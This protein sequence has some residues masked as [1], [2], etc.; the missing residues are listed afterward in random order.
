MGVTPGTRRGVYEITAQIGEGGM[1]KVFRARDTRL[2]REVAIKVIAAPLVTP[3]R[4]ARFER[5]A[6]ALA[7]LNHPH[8]AQVYG[9]NRPATGGARDI[10]R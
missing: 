9:S 7:S 8:I 4:V 6:M 3:E 10:A 5:E 1:G 2:N